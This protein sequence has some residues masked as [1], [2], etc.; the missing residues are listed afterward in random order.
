MSSIQWP[1]ICVASP[2]GLKSDSIEPW[3]GQRSSTGHLQH[4]ATLTREGIS[5]KQAEKLNNSVSL[6]GLSLVYAQVVWP[7]AASG[8]QLMPHLCQPASQPSC[9]P[10]VMLQQIMSPII[11]FEHFIHPWWQHV[12]RLCASCRWHCQHRSTWH[13]AVRQ[14]QS[15]DRSHANAWHNCSAQTHHPVCSVRIRGTCTSRALGVR[16]LSHLTPLLPFRWH[17]F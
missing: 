7:T 11:Q 12:Q 2:A 17:M 8:C 5:H 14:C 6:T 13:C 15:P 3:N 4:L 9:Q 10:C 16:V 1:E